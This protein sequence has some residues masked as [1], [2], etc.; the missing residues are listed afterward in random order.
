MAKLSP[1]DFARY[2][3][4]HGKPITEAKLAQLRGLPDGGGLPF[5]KESDDSKFVW[6]DTDDFDKWSPEEKSKQPTKPLKKYTSTRE[7]EEDLKKVA[8]LCG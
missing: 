7:S 4:E 1:K 5:Y 2:S 6:Y 8:L 3:T